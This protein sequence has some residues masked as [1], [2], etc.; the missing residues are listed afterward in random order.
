[1]DNK[2]KFDSTM[3]ALTEKAKTKTGKIAIISFLLLLLVL[4]IFWSAM[5]STVAEEMS[6]GTA[7]AEVQSLKNALASFDLRVAELE[8]GTTLD[9]ETV[10]GHVESMTKTAENFE[11][12]LNAVVKAEEAK[13]EILA[14]DMENHK[15]YIEE[16]KSL[17]A[18]ETGK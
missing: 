5:K 12:K 2:E 14:K 16:L 1:M 18:G 7:A 10:K 9:M 4:N 13:L 6:K 15:A 3:K 8:K 11:A 17:L